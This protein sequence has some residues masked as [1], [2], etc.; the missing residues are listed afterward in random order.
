MK[1]CDHA[2]ENW[3]IFRKCILLIFLSL[4]LATLFLIKEKKTVATPSGA[5]EF[6]KH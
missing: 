5:S 3:D 6:D 2:L 4:F 1:S